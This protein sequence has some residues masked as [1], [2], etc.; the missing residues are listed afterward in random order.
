M[1]DV[2]EKG[3]EELATE[4][5]K[6]LGLSIRG[7]RIGKIDSN[8]D[9]GMTIHCSWSTP[10][11]IQL[12]V[13]L[14][15]NES[16]DEIKAE[17]EK[18][19]KPLLRDIPGTQSENKSVRVLLVED[20]V[21]FA[22][23]ISTALAAF[24]VIVEAVLNAERAV[25]LLREKRFDALVTDLHL[26]QMS[27]VDLVEYVLAERLIDASRILV[28]TGERDGRRIQWAR[29]PGVRVLHKPVTASEL[30]AA[31]RTIV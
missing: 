29:L 13:R 26:E 19:L 30:N 11:R 17:I 24:N 14:R 12:A 6:E 28:L 18:Q 9:K 22:K 23:I 4:V 1:M 31:L 15:G 2:Q 21:L 10:Y 16:N 27:G 25:D 7:F 20:D 8:E 3:L 5:A